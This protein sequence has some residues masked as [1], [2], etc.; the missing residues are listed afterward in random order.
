MKIYMVSL[1]HRA[2]IN[3]MVCPITKGGH[4]NRMTVALVFYVRF[5]TFGWCRADNRRPLMMYQMSL[6]TTHQAPMYLSSS[7]YSAA[8]DSC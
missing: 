5:V 8:V 2:T 4:N 3:I 1:L 6:Q 7:L